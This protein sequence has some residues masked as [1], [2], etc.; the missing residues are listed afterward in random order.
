MIPSCVPEEL[1]GLTQTEEMLISRAFP[2]MNVY[3]KPRGGQRAYKGHVITFPAN[4]QEVADKLPNLPEDLPIVRLVSA[5]S[6]FKSK[7]FRVR[8]MKVLS[9]LQWLVRNNPVYRDV[10][11]DHNRIMSLPADDLITGIKKVT[12]NVSDKDELP[13]DRG[14]TISSDSL[15]E[16]NNSFLPLNLNTKKQSDLIFEQANGIELEFVGDNPYNEFSTEFIAT[17]AFPTLFPDA[18]GDPTNFALPRDIASSDTE[19]F[20]LKI[21]H[22]MKFGECI[23]SKWYYRFAAHPRFAYWAFNI[24][25]RKRILSKGNLYVKRNPGE[26]DFTLEEFNEMAR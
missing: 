17:M 22:L 4:V 1:K 6:E 9:A 11:I 8:R 25:Y 23:D 18:K 26:V 5:T 2:V 7:D 16:E 24:L 12:L 15:N 13:P 3:C 21:K 14:P 10:V 20:S 19:S